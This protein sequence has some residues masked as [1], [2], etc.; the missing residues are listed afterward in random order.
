MPISVT[1]N[2]IDLI[3]NNSLSSCP[4]EMHYPTGFTV[5]KHPS[6]NEKFTTPENSWEDKDKY[7]Q[8][9][10]ELMHLFLDQAKKL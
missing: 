6:I 4:T 8:K 1:R 5:P 9:A 2:I 7:E 10:S 3:L